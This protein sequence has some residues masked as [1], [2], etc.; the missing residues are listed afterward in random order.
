MT[1]YH[2]LVVRLGRNKAIMAVAHSILIIIYHMLQRGTSYIDLGYF[3]FDQ[4]YR[5]SVERRL[6]RNLERL[7]YRVILQ[8]SA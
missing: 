4:L 5:Q 6:T 3:Y 2:R 7:G 1:Q 8:P